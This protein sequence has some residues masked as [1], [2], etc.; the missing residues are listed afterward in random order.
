MA[1]MAGVL[2][3]LAA[4]SA[5]AQQGGDLP[6]PVDGV[7]IEQRL[8]AQIPLDAEF[9][10]SRGKKVTLK[11]YFTDRPVILVLAYY[12]C[13]MLCTEV[14]NGLVHSLERISLDPGGDYQWVVVSFNPR[15]KPP[16]AAANKRGYAERFGRG[17]TDA[18]WHFLTGEEEEIRRL[19][20]AV[21][22]RYRYDQ[23]TSQYVHGAGI[24]IA[25]PEGRLSRYMY[26]VDFPPGDLRL[27]LVEASDNQIGSIVDQ[28][29]LYCFQYD[30]ARGKYTADVMRIVRLGGG[31]TVAVLAVFVGAIWWKGPKKKA[32]HEAPASE[33]TDPPHDPGNHTP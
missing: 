17:G 15:E 30:P 23:A 21:G 26:G 19:A 6:S 5:A 1:C 8:D 11:E 29:H 4:T 12:R 2:L 10:D 22:F 13:P 25:T 16:L 28:V 7:G 27:A 33:S 9:V 20:Q 31:L 14:L 32:V 24:M 18:G 3:M